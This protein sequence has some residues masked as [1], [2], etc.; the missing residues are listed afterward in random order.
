MMK[1]YSIGMKL[2]DVVK[3]ENIE[4]TILENIRRCSKIVG[5]TFKVV[6]W[7]ENLTE[8]DCKNFVSFH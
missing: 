1:Y 7:H 3:D 6:F 4:Q 5:K 2:D 8:K